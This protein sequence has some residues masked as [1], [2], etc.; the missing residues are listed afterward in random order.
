MEM[1][2]LL[3]YVVAIGLPLWLLGEQAVAWWMFRSEREDPARQSAVTPVAP[4]V[5]AAGMPRMH[6][7]APEVSSKAA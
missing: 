6:A 2:E 1:D 5:P 4:A 7:A 3:T